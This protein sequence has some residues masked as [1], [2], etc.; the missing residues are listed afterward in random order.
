M[1]ESPLPPNLGAETVRTT[2]HGP[3]SC[4]CPVGGHSGVCLGTVNSRNL[5]TSNSSC[6]KLWAVFLSGGSCSASLAC[7]AALVKWDD[8]AGSIAD[9]GR[10]RITPAALDKS[11]VRLVFKYRG[12]VKLTVGFVKLKIAKACARVFVQSPAKSHR[13]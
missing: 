6:L 1:V 4:D 8:D 7:A 2:S 10:P 13:N 3:P 9:S 5:R 11:M 12:N